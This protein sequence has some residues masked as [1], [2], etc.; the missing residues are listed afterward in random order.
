MALVAAVIIA[1]G[2]FGMGYE[3]GGG[4]SKGYAIY[5]GDCYAGMQVASCT[6]DGVTWGVRG[7]VAWTDATNVGRGGGDDPSEWPACLPPMQE[8]KGVRFAGAWLPVGPSGLAA[9]IVWV[10][11]RH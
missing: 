11:C 7:Q 6:A 9:T 4:G 5:T 1:A 3:V 8:A 2:L 10:D